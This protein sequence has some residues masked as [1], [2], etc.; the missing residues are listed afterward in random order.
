MQSGFFDIP[1]KTGFSYWAL[2]VNFEKGIVWAV[3]VVNVV[4]NM[5]TPAVDR[6]Y[7][8]SLLVDLALL[9]VSPGSQTYFFDNVDKVERS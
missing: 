5:D 9:P 1:I 8:L 6:R 2:S 7:M 4:L 3:D